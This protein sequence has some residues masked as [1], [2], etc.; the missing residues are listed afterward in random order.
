MSSPS[1]HGAIRNPGLPG[2]SRFWGHHFSR[3]VAGAQVTS[4]APVA[5]RQRKTFLQESSPGRVVLDVPGEAQMTPC[6]QGFQ[7]LSCRKVSKSSPVHRNLTGTEAAKKEG[8][9]MRTTQ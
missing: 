3:S 8:A 7:K 1:T 4:K 9:S 2:F 6:E 5:Q